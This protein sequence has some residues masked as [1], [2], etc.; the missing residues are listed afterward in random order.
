MNSKLY[1]LVIAF[2]LSFLN[3]SCRP[4][5]TIQYSEEDEMEYTSDEEV[6]AEKS[7]KVRVDTV[8]LERYGEGILQ[9]KDLVSDST[10][11]VRYS[12]QACPPC[13]AIVD[14]MLKR[15]VI[16]KPMWKVVKIYKGSSLRDTYVK[17][18]NDPLAVPYYITNILPI[19]LNEGT[20]P[21]MFKVDSSGRAVDLYY[22][23]YGDTIKIKEYLGIM[24]Q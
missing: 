20:T 8:R 19:D 10:L 5:N 9:L 7:G 1:I 14:E 12:A 22:Q 15:Y 6:F 24:N 17:E 18:K 11:L 23:E 4:D 13:V 2:Q 3:W 16:E 21:I